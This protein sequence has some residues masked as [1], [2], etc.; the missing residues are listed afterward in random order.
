MYQTVQMYHTG[1]KTV[2]LVTFGTLGTWYARVIL[3]ELAFAFV[4][5]DSDYHKSLRSSRG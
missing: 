1:H 4:T 2:T 3:I 5:F